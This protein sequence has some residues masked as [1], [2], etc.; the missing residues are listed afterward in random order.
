MDYAFNTHPR[1]H[2]PVWISQDNHNHIHP[3]LLTREHRAGDFLRGF[4]RYMGMGFG[5]WVSWGKMFVC[6]RG[7]LSKGFCRLPR[8]NSKRPRNGCVGFQELF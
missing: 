3:F 7:D 4:S 8:D 2:F 6:F 1:P 5:T